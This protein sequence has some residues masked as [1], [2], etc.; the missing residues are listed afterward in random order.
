MPDIIMNE[1]DRSAVLDKTV[2]D[3]GRAGW[4]V[5]S[6]TAT[7]ASLIKGKPTSHLLH[8]ILSLITF[9][10]W[11]PVWILVAILSGQKTAVITVDEHGLVRR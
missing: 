8:L 2:G 5:E 7:Q 11:I 6:R 4:R 3:W 10:L 1:N 9:G